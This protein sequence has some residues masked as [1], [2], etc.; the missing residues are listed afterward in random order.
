MGTLLYNIRQ[1]SICESHLPLEANPI[2]SFLS[3]SKIILLSQAPGKIAHQKTKAW[4]DP[5]CRK[6]CKWLG[7]N[8]AQF[9]NPD[10]F[11]ILPIGFCYPGKA[12]TG[13]LPPR[14]EC[15]PL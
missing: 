10:N 13:D 14:P 5:S 15:A 2:V 8:E 4:D 7:V 1:C 11:A 9:Y 3:Q 12:T 6:L